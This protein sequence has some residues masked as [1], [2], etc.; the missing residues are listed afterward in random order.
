MYLYCQTQDSLLLQRFINPRMMIYGSSYC[1]PILGV[2]GTPGNPPKHVP[3]VLTSPELEC[4]F[5]A[6]SGILSQPWIAM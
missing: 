1:K 5:Q 2:S 3:A 6:L 4:H